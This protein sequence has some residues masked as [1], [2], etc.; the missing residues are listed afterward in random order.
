MTH[1]IEINNHIPRRPRIRRGW[2]QVTLQK[3]GPIKLGIM[4]YRVCNR[5][6]QS[7]FEKLTFMYKKMQKTK[8]PTTSAEQISPKWSYTIAGLNI[9]NLTK[10][11]VSVQYRHTRTSFQA[12]SINKGNM[13]EKHWNIQKETYK[14]M[15]VAYST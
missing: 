15:F 11:V 2:C 6:E 14:Q 1:P 9:P 5:I 7:T 10:K 13:K 4:V 12:T 8:L 3:K